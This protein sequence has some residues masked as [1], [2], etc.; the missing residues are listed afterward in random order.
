MYS[1]VRQGFWR[2]GDPAL[3]SFLQHVATLV[4]TNPG[5]GDGLAL[6]FV[7]TAPVDG[8]LIAALRTLT[9]WYTRLA[10]TAPSTDLAVVMRG[11]LRILEWLALNC[12]PTY[13]HQFRDQAGCVRQALYHVQRIVR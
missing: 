13:I 8:S 5:D 7:Q 12:D 11:H 3:T 2:V 9:E 4:G 1:E 10:G 6:A